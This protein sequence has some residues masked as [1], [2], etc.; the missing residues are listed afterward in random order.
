M[1]CLLALALA[2]LICSSITCLPGLDEG[3]EVP[4]FVTRTL[5]QHG[6]ELP[7]PFALEQYRGGTIV[8]LCWSETGHS[9]RL[10]H[11][12]LAV[13]AEQ[14][15]RAGHLVLGVS[16]D[17]ELVRQ[18]MEEI[19]QRAPIAIVSAEE[20]AAFGPFHERQRRLVI[21]GLGLVAAAPKT[22]IGPESLPAGAAFQTPYGR[23]MGLACPFHTT[24]SRVARLR[25]VQNRINRGQIGAALAEAR[26][27]AED[28]DADEDLRGESQYL[29]AQCEEWIQA[30]SAMETAARE[31]GDQYTTALIAEALATALDDDPRAA[32]AA[33]RA[34]TAADQ[35]A[36]H[37]G[38]RFH[39]SWRR[40]WGRSPSRRAA[41]YRSLLRSLDE[42]TYHHDLC[43]HWLGLID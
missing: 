12:E 43:A 25:S 4:W 9:K 21:N 26:A 18:G 13:L 14:G 37:A 30:A 22:V 24:P 17:A 28:T 41:A 34:E 15:R 36:Y 40:T 38:K 23:W 6:R 5:L 31:A 32:A 33:Q 19:G 8:L 1:V 29:I 2:L 27:Y 16:D 11:E 39:R 42:G 20:M 10:L 3:D 35:P 7:V